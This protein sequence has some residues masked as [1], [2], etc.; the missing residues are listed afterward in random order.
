MSF[1]FRTEREEREREGE[2]VERERLFQKMRN[3]QQRQDV[4]RSKYEK[5][6]DICLKQLGAIIKTFRLIKLN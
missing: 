6:K 2:R 5:S 4:I 3:T 1:F